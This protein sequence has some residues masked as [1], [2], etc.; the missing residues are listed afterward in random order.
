MF[1]RFVVAQGL[2]IMI[3]KTIDAHYIKVSSKSNL[4]KCKRDYSLHFVI[5][6]M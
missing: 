3:M 2:S 1:I 4:V 5:L 6:V